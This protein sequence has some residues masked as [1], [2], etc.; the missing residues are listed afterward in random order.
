MVAGLV[1]FVG[2]CL[3]PLFVADVGIIYYQR[4]NLPEALNAYEKSLV[5]R[6]KLNDPALIASSM[7]KIALVYHDMGDYAKSLEKQLK[8]LEIYKTLGIQPV[9]YTH[10][11]LPTNR[12]V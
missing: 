1:Y 3:L 10:L 11:T 6:E 8:I 2:Y 9:S 5:I 4:G 7:N 12:E